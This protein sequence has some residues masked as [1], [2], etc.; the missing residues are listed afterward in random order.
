MSRPPMPLE[1]HRLVGRGNG[2]KTMDGRPLP[3]ASTV[4]ALPMADGVPEPPA[5]LGLEGRAFWER[6]WGQAIT[7]VSP[8]SDME[9]IVQAARLVDKLAD[10][11]RAWDATQDVKYINAIVKLNERLLKTLSEL[12]FT[13]TGRSRLGVAE[14]KR[15][16]GLQELLA[17]RNNA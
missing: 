13:P 2:T 17:K 1:H 11:S 5:D 12:G 10:V 9:T 16:T 14:V 6:S 15:A 7:W 8:D 4:V 3:E